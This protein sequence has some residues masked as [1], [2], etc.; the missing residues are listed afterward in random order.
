MLFSLS[1]NRLPRIILISVYHEKLEVQKTKIWHVK[2]LF[3]RKKCGQDE[4]SPIDKSYEVFRKELAS[5]TVLTSTQGSSIQVD[6]QHTSSTQRTPSILTSTRCSQKSVLQSDRLNKRTVENCSR[7]LDTPMYLLKKSMLKN[8]ILG[9]RFEV[10]TS[11]DYEAEMENLDAYLIPDLIVVQQELLL[12]L[13]LINESK[14]SFVR[15]FKQLDLMNTAYFQALSD[16]LNVDSDKLNQTHANLI[17]CQFTIRRLLIYLQHMELENSAVIDLT[18]N[19]LKSTA[20]FG[21]SYETRCFIAELVLRYVESLF[22]EIHGGRSNVPEYDFL[23]CEKYLTF[24]GPFRASSPVREPSRLRSRI[25]PNAPKKVFKYKMEELGECVQEMYDRPKVN[26]VRLNFT[27]SDEENDQEKD[28]ENLR[29]KISELRST[30]APSSR[31][32]V[33]LSRDATEGGSQKMIGECQRTGAVSKASTLFN[34]RDRSDLNSLNDRMAMLGLDTPEVHEYLI[35]ES[36]NDRYTE[37]RELLFKVLDLFGGY[38][39]IEHYNRINRLL[40]RLS[41]CRESTFGS[42]S[43]YYFS[44]ICQANA[45]RCRTVQNLREKPDPITYDNEVLQFSV[46][47][48]VDCKNELKKVV[49]VLPIDWRVLQIQFL[50]SGAGSHPDLYLARYQS[51]RNPILLKINVN[52]EKVSS[53]FSVELIRINSV[54]FDHLKLIFILI[55]LNSSPFP[56]SSPSSVQPSS[57]NSTKS[58]S[59]PA[60]W[61][62]IKTE[63]ASGSF[64]WH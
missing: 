41:T 36:S 39:S 3:V 17:T 26:S 48:L 8:P 29:M 53:K 51:D 24:W 63:R 9:N 59:Y 4:I 6:T 5:N 64:A 1:F 49:D 31:K 60:K 50:E 12:L 32:D 44:E 23:E 2:N 19:V 45:L 57:R 30:R 28:K 10:Q 55:A 43:P 22:K 37:F 25:K 21:H 14:S 16:A 13:Y 27:E 35:D 42:E 62:R 7:T 34:S 38:P 61:P 54:H 40:F 46:S 20:N 58:F 11:P 15:H 47:G 18:R 33:Q 56:P 52:S